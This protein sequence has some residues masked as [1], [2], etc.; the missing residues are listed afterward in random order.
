MLPSRDYMPVP[1]R[2]GSCVAG[3]MGDDATAGMFVRLTDQ[4]FTRETYSGAPR[5][6]GAPVAAMQEVLTLSVCK[7]RDAV[8]LAQREPAR[9]AGA[10]YGVLS[11]ATVS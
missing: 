10:E 5:R 7:R 1:R 11:G 9:P 3:W 2:V 8:R 6:S 4:T